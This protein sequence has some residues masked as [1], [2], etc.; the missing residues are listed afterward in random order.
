MTTINTQEQAK[1][2]RELLRDSQYLLGQ[3]IEVN[4][5]GKYPSP[6]ARLDN[7]DFKLACLI[8]ELKAVRSEVQGE[9]KVLYK[10]GGK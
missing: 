7:V 3:I 10:R 6:K 5:V 2:H 9:L 8:D 4:S 1:V